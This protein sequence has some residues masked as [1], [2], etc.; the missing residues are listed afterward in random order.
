[1]E[2]MVTVYLA[3]AAF[4]VA[5]VDA[6]NSTGFSKYAPQYWPKF[7]GSREVVLLDSEL[8]NWEYGFIDS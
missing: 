6:T 4:V 5:T 1:M 2:K 3:L 8:E 7:G